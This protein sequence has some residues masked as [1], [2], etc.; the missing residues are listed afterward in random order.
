MPA[1]PFTTQVAAQ[2]YDLQTFTILC[3]RKTITLAEYD[4]LMISR[5]A[6]LGT[7]NNDSVRK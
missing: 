5:W 1:P 7:A 2:T 3:F 6:H 4:R